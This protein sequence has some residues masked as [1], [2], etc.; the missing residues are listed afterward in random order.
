M[1][2]ELS[3]T[4]KQERC[5]AQAVKVVANRKLYLSDQLGNNPH[6]LQVRRS[7]AIFSNCRQRI[8]VYI[9]A[10]LARGARKCRRTAAI[11]NLELPSRCCAWTRVTRRRD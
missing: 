5:I 8:R 9:S 11:W 1:F 2:L 3:T 4:F 6:D 10:R 7:E